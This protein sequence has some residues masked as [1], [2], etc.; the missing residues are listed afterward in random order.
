MSHILELTSQTQH[1]TVFAAPRARFYAPLLHPQSF[2]QATTQNS[3]YLPKLSLTLPWQLSLA[4]IVPSLSM[5]GPILTL[6][7][8]L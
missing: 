1:T 8:L 2:G 7:T 6:L 4:L 3:H 5:V